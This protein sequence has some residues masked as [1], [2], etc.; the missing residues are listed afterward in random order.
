MIKYAFFIILFTSLTSNVFGFEVN[1]HENISKHAV[2]YIESDLNRI[3]EN[4]TGTKN[5]LSRSLKNSRIPL[6]FFLR[7]IFAASFTV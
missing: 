1:T 5:S 4:Q 2:M 6:R 3:L 7:R